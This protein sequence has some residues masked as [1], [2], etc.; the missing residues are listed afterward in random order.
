MYM[1]TYEKYKNARNLAWNILIKYNL[2]S[3]PIDIIE[4]ANKL[5][6]QIYKVNNLPNDIYAFNTIKTNKKII[7]YKDSGNIDTN[8]FTIAHELGHILLNHSNKTK[9]YK[10]EQ[11]NIFASR[12]LCPLCIIKHYNFDSIADISEF[13]GI[14]EES[15]EIRLNRFNTIATRNKF[16]SNSLERNY[17]YNYCKKNNTKPKF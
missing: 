17:Y 12:L 11:A 1:D 3:F 6:I 14:S 8:R 5:N 13:F 16:L 15:A 9:E 2:Y 10:E 4:L 7:C